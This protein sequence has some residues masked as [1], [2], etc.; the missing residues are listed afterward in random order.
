MIEH[1][2]VEYLPIVI[3]LGIAV[4]LAT[5]MIAIPFVIAIKNPDTEKLGLRMRV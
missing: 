2:L 4:A 3:F 5:V 1:A